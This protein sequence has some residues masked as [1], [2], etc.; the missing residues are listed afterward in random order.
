MTFTSDLVQAQVAL[1]LIDEVHLLNENR[2]AALEAG[3]VS[4][5]KMIGSLEAMKEVSSST[6]A[7]HLVTNHCLTAALKSRQNALLSQHLRW[8]PIMNVPVCLYAAANLQSALP[9]RLS[10]N[11]EHW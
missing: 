3:V 8:I 5:I 1:L 10:N 7:M 6:P 4:R 9:G 2:G 11:P